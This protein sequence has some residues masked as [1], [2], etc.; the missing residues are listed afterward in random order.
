MT[1]ESVSDENLQII[2]ETVFRKAQNEKEYCIFY[3]DLCEK[4]IKLEL[5]LKNMKAT[6]KNIKNSQYRKLLLKNCKASFD[7]FFTEETKKVLESKDEE[8]LFK[9]TMRLFGNIKFVGELYRRGLLQDSIIL[10]VFDM[11]MAIE[12]KEQLQ[13]VN[14]NTIEGSVVLMEKI[15]HLLDSKLQ[16]YEAPS[17]KPARTADLESADK[18]RKT[19]G[20]FDELLDEKSEPP[21]STRS[22]MLILNMLDNRKSNWERSKKLE[23]SG[24][25]KV[26]DLRQHLEKKMLE[27]QKIRDDAE[28]EE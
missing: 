14:D 3:G 26:D 22:R 23:D 25:M 28:R 21:I 27:E 10:S 7:Q 2:V 24:P 19:F 13:F 17:D 16:N 12:S 18:I 6:V 15:G 11:L 20:R 1:D 8:S 5:N 4:I 9:F